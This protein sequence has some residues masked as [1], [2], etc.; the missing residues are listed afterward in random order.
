MCISA[1]IWITASVHP[2]DNAS[3]AGASVPCQPGVRGGE[4][5]HHTPAAVPSPSGVLQP[6]LPLTAAPTQVMYTISQFTAG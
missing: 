2:E 3:A 6:M 5:G 4:G 1:P